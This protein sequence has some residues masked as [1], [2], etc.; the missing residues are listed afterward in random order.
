MH[1]ISQD[2]F[3]LHFYA[4][5]FFPGTGSVAAGFHPPRHKRDTA[6]SSL[7][8]LVIGEPADLFMGSTYLSFL[9]LLLIEQ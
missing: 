6:T 2:F 8:R 4:L 3:S 1:I 5:F 9:F 7:D